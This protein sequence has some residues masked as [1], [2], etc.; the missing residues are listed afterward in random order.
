V[1]C[2]ALA[3]SP[4]LHEYCIPSASAVPSRNMSNLCRP[5]PM[6]CLDGYP[7]GPYIYYP[8]SLATT[9]KSL[10]P[11]RRKKEHLTQ[12]SRTTNEQWEKLQNLPAPVSR[13]E[14]LGLMLCARRGS[15]TGEELCSDLVTLTAEAKVTAEAGSPLSQA[16][17]SHLPGDVRR[18]VPGDFAAGLCTASSEDRL[19]RNFLPDSTAFPSPSQALPP[20]PSAGPPDASKARP[21]GG[22]GGGGVAGE[23]RRRHEH[24]SAHMCV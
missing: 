1:Y 17:S 10:K 15:T 7:L 21:V 2:I 8:H 9:A 18:R 20:A 14:N 12:K 5:A 11:C 13:C 16:S 4:A 24:R 23:M 6:R 3:V 19:G 22:G